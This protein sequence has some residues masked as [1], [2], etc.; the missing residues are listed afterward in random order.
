MTDE[1]IR[2]FWRLLD[3]SKI[4]LE[5]RDALRL[6]LLLGLRVREVI[7]ASKIEID[8]DLAVW[9][10]PA[11]RT[12]SHREHRLPL[13]TM[14]MTILKDALLRS[15]GTPWLFPSPVGGPMRSRSASHALIR[16]RERTK[17]LQD[18]GTHDL[19]RTLATRLGDSIHASGFRYNLDG[20][21]LEDFQELPQAD[22]E[23]L[24]TF[25]AKNTDQALQKAKQGYRNASQTGR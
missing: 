4:S 2:L 13:P 20:C 17:M 5:I 18:V 12:K 23:A 16:L 9:T 21:S 10:I 7:G 8:L 6:Q 1:E 24:R 22:F 25:L 11:S 14:A 15:E 19:R 3:T